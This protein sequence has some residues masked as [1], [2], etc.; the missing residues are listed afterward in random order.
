M[1][2]ELF[3]GGTPAAH[4][5]SRR[6]YKRFLRQYS[7][8]FSPLSSPP[9]R[10]DIYSLYLPQHFCQFSMACR[11]MCLRLYA[12]TQAR[13]SYNI[14]GWKYCSTCECYIFTQQVICACCG[15]RLR[16][17]PH[18]GRVNKEK[19]RAKKKPIAVV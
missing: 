5:Y 2:P 16:A 4:I 12:I 3:L 15:K 18:C 17:N 10:G 8:T 14:T 19:F 13:V 7:V 1:I 9:P 6:K 11:N